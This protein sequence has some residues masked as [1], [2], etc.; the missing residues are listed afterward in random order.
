VGLT[1]PKTI[2]TVVAGR[3]AGLEL[4][5]NEAVLPGALEG[6]RKAGA[7][8]VVV[9]VDDCFGPLSRLFEAHP[10]WKADLVVGSRCDEVNEAKVREVPFFAVGD[11]LN[12]YVSARI[13]VGA[14]AVK[15][16]AVRKALDEKGPEDADLVA[17]R[18][19]WQ[20]RLDHDLGTVIGFSK[21]GLKEDSAQLRT[22]VATALR[23]ETKSDA[24][25]INRKGIR[26]GLP[27]GKL[28][29]AHVYSMVPFENAVLTVIVT[30][31]VLQQL[32]GN[33]EAV[34]V[35]PAKLD[36]AKT[37]QLATT[38]YL[39]FGGDGLGL[40][41]LAP[42][43]EL[44]GQVWQTPVVAWLTKQGSSEKKPLEKLLK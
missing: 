28:T 31:A 43:P 41:A 19:R 44:T 40:E 15:V 30:G 21:T 22:L 34:L 7:E 17:L 35:A 23:D 2:T 13:E 29:A 24:A 33:P 12:F 1:G 42:S 8:V 39:Y 14:G 37:Y 32:K 27:K 36:P 20:E 18:T 26:A 4:L 25:L 38:E 5:S 9:L 16:T 6:A 3:A 10:D 11:D